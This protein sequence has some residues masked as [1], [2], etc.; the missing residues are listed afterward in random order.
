M[1]ACL[2][3]V[4]ESNQGETEIQVAVQASIKKVL[5][6]Y[7]WDEIRELQRSDSLKGP[8]YHAMSKNKRPSQLGQ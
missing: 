4:Q 5:N 8:I 2:W 6:N 7:S 1:R 3:P